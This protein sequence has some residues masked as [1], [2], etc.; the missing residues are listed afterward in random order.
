MKRFRDSEGREW[1]VSLTVDTVRRVKGTLDV[2][3]LDLQKDSLLA[4][5]VDD[6]IT[7][8]DV[9]YVICRPEADERG[10][11]DEQFGRC[12]AGDVIDDA[13]TALLEGLVDFFPRRRREV[14]QK[15]LE[16][17]KHLEDRSIQ[18]ALARLDDPELEAR[19]EREFAAMSGEP[20]TSSPGSSESAPAD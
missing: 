15:A 17:L 7:L 16:K 2:D 12:L 11:T 14:L 13:T 3:L 19:I 5:L 10:I 4:R 1:L 18:L 6:P 8:C 9:L 20:S